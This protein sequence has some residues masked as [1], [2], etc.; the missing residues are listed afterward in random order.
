MYSTKFLTLIT[1]LST[2]I[3][4]KTVANSTMKQNWFSKSFDEMYLN[5]EKE[6]NEAAKSLNL[7][8]ARSSLSPEALTSA[9]STLLQLR[10]FRQL[11]EFVVWMSKNPKFGKYCFYG[12]WCLPGG[13]HEF[14]AGHGEPRDEI[15]KACKIQWQC[16]ECTVMDEETKDACSPEKAKYDFEF[17]F[18][19]SDPEDVSKHEITLES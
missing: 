4:S 12:C 13:G 6:L 18:D 8:S 5:F 14:V 19:E 2:T 16:Y 7:N 15:D 3:Q 17:G 11:K 1:A 10:R 9:E